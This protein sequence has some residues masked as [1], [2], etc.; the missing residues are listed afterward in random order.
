VGHAE[1]TRPDLTMKLLAA[2][3][4]KQFLL[5]LTMAAT[6]LPSEGELKETDLTHATHSKQ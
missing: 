6:N 2:A 5:V 1:L 4:I 3:I